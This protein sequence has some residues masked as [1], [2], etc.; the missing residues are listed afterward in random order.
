MENMAKK[1]AGS[2]YDSLPAQQRK[3]VCF[4]DD[5]YNCQKTINQVIN[6]FEGAKFRSTKLAGYFKHLMTLDGSSLAFCSEME[7]RASKLYQCASLLTVRQYLDTGE[8]EQSAIRC[9]QHLLCPGCAIIRGSRTMTKIIDKVQNNGLHQYKPYLLT[10]TVKDDQDLDRAFKNL[11]K[12]WSRLLDQRKGRNGYGSN[13]LQALVGG[14]ATIEIIRGKNSGLW[15]PHLH[16]LV[17]ADRNLEVVQDYSGRYRWPALSEAWLNVTGDSKIIECHPIK[18]ISGAEIGPSE[19]FESIAGTGRAILPD[20]FINAVCEVSKY[21]LKLSDLSD[22]DVF[23]VWQLV[24]G[25]RL[26]R[27]FGLMRGGLSDFEDDIIPD[28]DTIR[29]YTEWLYQ[30]TKSGY[31]LRKAQISPFPTK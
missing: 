22:R 20:G 2:D 24:K 7:S 12:N 13:P 25:R 10:V 31:S 19:A 3:N 28:S 18:G 5:D 14:V 29:R 6:R 8:I 23:E 21:A 30:W 11:T 15:H 1:K 17:F 16:A 26:V 9:R 27:S 4:R